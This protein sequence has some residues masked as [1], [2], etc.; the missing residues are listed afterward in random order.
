MDENPLLFSVSIDPET[1]T[2]LA[3]AA[4]WA[5]FLAIS[6]FILLG[7]GVTIAAYSAIETTDT[8]VQNNL[9][10]GGTAE[11][12]GMILGFIVMGLIPFFAL[13]FV[14]RFSN[15]MNKALSAKDQN[16]LNTSFKTLKIYFRYMGIIT[17]I[18]LVL[19]T[20][21]WLLQ[22]GSGLLVGR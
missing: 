20:I 9:N 1:R 3:E 22:A 10:E 16:R 7:V 18:F 14:L 19:I 6:G 2:N 8:S 15:A 12:A 17:V 21:S 5:R 13:L 4:R 11:F